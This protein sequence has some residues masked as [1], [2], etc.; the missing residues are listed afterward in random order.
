MLFPLGVSKAASSV[1]YTSGQ[2]TLFEGRG[3]SFLFWHEILSAA[4]TVKLSLVA[5]CVKSRSMSVHCDCFL[6]LMLSQDRL[7]NTAAPPG[8]QCLWTLILM[9]VPAGPRRPRGSRRGD[10]QDTGGIAAGPFT[11]G[12]LSSC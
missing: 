6:T 8:P 12:M 9:L 7:L 11:P 10:G 2:W 5:F 4:I 3:L 1:F